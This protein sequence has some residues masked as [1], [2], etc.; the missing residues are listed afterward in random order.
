MNPLNLILVPTLIVFFGKAETTKLFLND[1]VRLLL[2]RF[3]TF[4]PSFSFSVLANF[5]KRLTRWRKSIILDTW[6]PW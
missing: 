6:M 2:C 4:Y 5:G 3:D 1:M